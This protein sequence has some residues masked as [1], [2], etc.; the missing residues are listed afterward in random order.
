MPRKSSPTEADRIRWLA[1]FR[2]GL[3]G[4]K[5]ARR[6]RRSPSSVQLAI[7]KAR[8]QE[9]AAERRAADLV[10]AAM[11]ERFELETRNHFDEI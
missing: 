8:L 5:I 11:R 7:R 6:F 1:L 3:S 4:R 9:L 10:V 2:Q